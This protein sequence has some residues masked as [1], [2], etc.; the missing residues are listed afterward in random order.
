MFTLTFD[1]LK[2]VNRLK[3]AGV[4]PA[5]A[6]A[7]VEALLE[8]LKTCL[9]EITTKADLAEMKFEL[10]KWIIGVAL[11][12]VAQVGLLIGLLKFVP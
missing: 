2:F 1:T 10:F 11:V 6:E 9:K 3:T 4:S 7:E 12:N 5:Q 8:V